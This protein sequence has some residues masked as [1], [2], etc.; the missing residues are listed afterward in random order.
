MFV[1]FPNADNFQ[2]N[3]ALFIAAWKV[4]YKRFDEH[5][6]WREGRMPLRSIEAP[7]HYLL[8]QGHRFSVE[9]LCRLMVPWHARSKTQANFDFLTLNP[10][11]L[12]SVPYQSIQGTEE[13]GARLTDQA[14][15]Y[16]DSLPY[17]SQDYYLALAEARIQADIETPHD[18]PVVID[19]AGI[20]IIGEDIYPLSIPE[21]NASEVEYLKSL[22]E[23][24]QHDP[25]Q[26]MYQRKAVGESVSGWEQ[27]LQ[28]LFWP[29]PRINYSTLHSYLDPL[30]Y[31]TVLLA[32]KIEGQQA[33]N[34]REK[35]MAVK[36]AHA[37]FDFNGVPQREITV[38][39]VYHVID[40][41]LK[42]EAN[43]TAKM[44][45]GWTNLAS[46]ATVFLEGQTGRLPLAAWSSRVAASLTGR[47]DFLLVEA[48]HERHNGIF[49]GIGTVPG[50]G[51]TRPRELT[52]KWPSA[53]RS[54]ES[55]IAVSRYLATMRDILNN[56]C[57]DKGELK[58]PKMPL[59]HGGET[60]WTVRGVQL[61]LFADGY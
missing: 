60:A 7:L 55:Q 9:V 43:S 61:V 6:Q 53:Y 30:I 40:S 13:E 58:Y 2:V 51:G 16:W 42:A 37:V 28:G 54:W 18:A 12:R 27:R 17:V 49:P 29:K 47:L 41:A 56:T 44:N 15:D 1:I 22:V 34:H 31:R 25:Y 33:W 52:L 36:L 26:P 57:N 48:G 45:S 32:K 46:Y 35:R 10:A 8:N 3:R 50:D 5:L 11:L 20:V 59:P 24:I 39:N 14:L 21:K 4:W 23:W 38:E 19:D